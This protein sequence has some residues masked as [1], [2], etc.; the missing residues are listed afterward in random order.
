MKLE[1]GACVVGGRGGQDYDGCG[2]SANSKGLG[3]DFPR[4]LGFL[5]NG[6]VNWKGGGIIGH[7]GACCGHSEKC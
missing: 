5:E 3:L 4:M 1:V 2:L 6:C 7:L